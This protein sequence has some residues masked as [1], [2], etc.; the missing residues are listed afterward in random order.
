VNRDALLTL[1][2]EDQVSLILAQ[3]TQIE[4]QTA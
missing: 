2:K 3:V 4:A 1:S